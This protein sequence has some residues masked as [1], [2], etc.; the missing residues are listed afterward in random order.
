MNIMSAD[1]GFDPHAMDKFENVSVDE[2]TNVD[3]FDLSGKTN[4]VVNLSAESKD[5]EIEDFNCMQPGKVYMIIAT[6]GA[7][8]KNQVQ[9]P[10][11][12]TLYNATITAANAMTIC[13]KFWTDGSSIYCDRSIYS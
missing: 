8:T 2:L 9:L 12:S 3:G 10:S 4:M 1:C 6:N 7:S 11:A 13:Y 5:I